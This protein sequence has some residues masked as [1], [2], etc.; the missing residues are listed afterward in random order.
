MASLTRW[1]RVCVDSASWWWTGRPGVLRFM[2]SQRVGHNWVTELN[3]TE[4]KLNILLNFTEHYYFRILT[5]NPNKS[6][7]CLNM[8][9]YLKHHEPL[10]QGKITWAT[11]SCAP[12]K[13]NMTKKLGVQTFPNKDMQSFSKK[14]KSIE[15]LMGI[16]FYIFNFCM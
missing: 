14:K 2:G 6:L 3:W 12:F 1:T 7:L 9:T 8:Y 10:E 13:C 4:P 5:R 16:N 15:K 11:G